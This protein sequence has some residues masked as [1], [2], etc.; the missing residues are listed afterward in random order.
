ERQCPG[1]VFCLGGT[2]Q[3]RSPVRAIH[4]EGAV[5]VQLRGGVPAAVQAVYA[6][7]GGKP[8]E[9]R[10]RL[11]ADE[12]ERH[13]VDEPAFFRGY[14]RQVTQAVEVAW[15]EVGEESGIGL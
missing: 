10:R 9:V 2:G 14:T 15:S 6:D 13:A 4:R 1:Q 11:A 8:A 12:S 5:S 3:G 7:V